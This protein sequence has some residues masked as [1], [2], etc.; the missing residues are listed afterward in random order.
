MRRDSGRCFGFR[1]LD[2]LL[3]PA[4]FAIGDRDGAA[5]ALDDLARDGEPEPGA[6]NILPSRGVGAEERLE[7]LTE[8]IGRNTRTV[9]LDDDARGAIRPADLDP[10]SDPMRRRVDDEIAQRRD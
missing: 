6:A 1:Q 5:R 10:R 3:Q 8:Q 7:H 2:H 4:I 9:I